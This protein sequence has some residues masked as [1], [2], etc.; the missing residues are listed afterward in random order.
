MMKSSHYFIVTCFIL[1]LASFIIISTSIHVNPISYLAIAQQASTQNQDSEESRDNSIFGNGSGNS[2]AV[3]M[4]KTNISNFLDNI[5]YLKIRNAT[6]PAVAIDSKDGAIYL[7]FSKTE[8]NITN[9]YMSKSTDNGV[10]FSN[11]V[12]INQEVGDASPDAWTA[13]RILLGNTGEVFVIWHVIDE[14]NK[15]FAYGTSSLRLARSLDGGQSFEPTTNPANDTVGEKAFFGTAISP[16]DGRIYISYLDSLS[17]ITDF[18]IS[19]PSKVN[20]IQ[21]SDGGKTFDSPSTIDPTACDCCRTAI[22]VGPDGEAYMAWRHAS[23]DTAETYSNGSNPFNY[24]EKLG[25]GVAYQVVRDVFVAHSTDDGLISNLS[26]PVK[27]HNDSWFMNG[28]PSAGPSLSFDPNGRLHVTW[29]TGGGEMPGTYYVFS[30][31]NGQSFSTPLPVLTDEWIPPA[32]SNLAIDSQNN[33]WITTADKRNENHTNIFVGI[34]DPAGSL[35]ANN[36]F[37][38]GESPVISSGANKTAIGWTEG[39]NLNLAVASNDLF[40]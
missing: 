6:S 13:P 37:A 8:N 19:Y 39:S 11:P 22:T 32:D 2:S 28:C 1:C 20:V 14:S 9:M 18:T 7:S 15:E 25:E 12:R 33:I 16:S 3:N 21:S 27:V 35:T 5:N 23:H 38:V 34:I 26:A 24:D 29:F 17:N 4:M 10:S 30:D 31:D 40:V 36:A